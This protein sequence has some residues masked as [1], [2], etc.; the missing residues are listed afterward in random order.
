MADRD[1]NISEDLRLYGA[2]LEIPS[3]PRGKSQLSQKKLNFRK[4]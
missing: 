1:F 3:F 4:D 2:K